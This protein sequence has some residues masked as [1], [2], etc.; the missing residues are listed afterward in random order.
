MY[1]IVLVPNQYTVQGGADIWY[2]ELAPYQAY[3]HH[4]NE[5][6]PVQSSALRWPIL[7]ST[8]ILHF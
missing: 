2:A 8:P 6:A 5:V 7:L 1:C 3:T 4:I